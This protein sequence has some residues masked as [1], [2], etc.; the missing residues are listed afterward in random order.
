MSEWA[1]EKNENEY[2]FI[3][4]YAFFLAFVDSFFHDLNF[5]CLMYLMEAM[6]KGKVGKRRNGMWASETRKGNKRE[7]AVDLRRDGKGRGRGRSGPRVKERVV[8]KGRKRCKKK[9]KKTRFVTRIL[10]YC[11]K[12][13]WANE[14]IARVWSCENASKSAVLLITQSFPIMQWLFFSNVY[15]CVSLMFAPLFRFG[16]SQNNSFATL[17]YLSRSGRKKTGARRNM[18]I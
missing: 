5:L 17:F 15:V 7:K 16:A 2:T 4:I 14:S 18:N 9:K 8:K 6:Q 12:E 13:M 1:K 10:N 11:C 3:F